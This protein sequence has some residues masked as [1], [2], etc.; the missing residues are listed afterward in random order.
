MRRPRPMIL[1]A[2]LLLLAAACSSPAT[3]APSAAPT[4]TSTAPAGKDITVSVPGTLAADFD[5]L[6][7]TLHGRA[8]LAL[9][10]VGGTKMATLGDWTTGAAWSTI[11]VPLVLAVLRHNGD[12]T[13]ASMSA[14]ITESDNSAAD[15]LWQSLGT[16]DAAAAAVQAVLRDGG[17]STTSVPATRTRPDYSSFGQA[18]WALRDQLRFTAEL[19]CLD[20]ADTV[21]S[22]MA[23]ISGSQQWGLG[24]LE[25]SEYKGGWGPDAN[26]KYLVRQL[27]LVGTETGKL[28]IVLAAQPDSGSFDDGQAMLTKI[29]AV[30]SKHLDELPGGSCAPKR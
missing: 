2:G 28:A 16:P 21:T 8:G 27:G 23:K 17:D 3:V 24:H 20:D 22:L 10:P 15:V 14:A 13:T 25:G 29:A 1:G 11:K 19:P 18:T 30:V 5:D 12:T 4:S 26:G 7:P 9:M 6:L